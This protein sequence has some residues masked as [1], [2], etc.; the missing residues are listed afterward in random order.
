MFIYK[1]KSINFRFPIL[2]GMLCISPFIYGQSSQTESNSAF[3]EPP[4]TPFELRDYGDHPSVGDSTQAAVLTSEQSTM[5]LAVRIVSDYENYK[6]LGNLG[7]DLS[8]GPVQELVAIAWQVRVEKEE[9]YSNRV[10]RMCEYFY[11]RAAGSDENRIA[12][13]IKL[14]EGSQGE[15]EDLAIIDRNFMLKIRNEFGDDIYQNIL[16]A[17]DNLASSNLLYKSVSS[18]VFFKMDEAEFIQSSCEAK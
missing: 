16:Q 17:K 18:R 6:H 2:L 12:N 7:I 1:L 8:A 11:S 10:N 3:K 9:A 4:N 13:A 14:V 5:L 15:T